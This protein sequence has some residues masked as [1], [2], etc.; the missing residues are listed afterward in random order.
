MRARSSDGRPARRSGSE[1]NR[2]SSSAKNV[3]ISGKTACMSMWSSSANPD[4]HRPSFPARRWTVR[5][6]APRD[7]GLT[8]FIVLRSF[9]LKHLSELCQLWDHYAI[10]RLKVRSGV[11]AEDSIPTEAVDLA[12]GHGKAVA[13]F[14]DRSQIGQWPKKHREKGVNHDSITVSTYGTRTFEHVRRGI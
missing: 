7:G 5:E 11:V 8:D 9:G 10:K 12:Q 14:L 1:A 2:A 13:G 6:T 4:C 3:A